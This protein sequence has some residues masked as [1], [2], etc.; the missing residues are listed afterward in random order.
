M[1]PEAV[2]AV[3][4]YLRLKSDIVA[5]RFSP[6][7]LLVE[8]KIAAEYDMSIVPLRDA[9]QRLL[10]EGLIE[11]AP[12][13]GYRLPV[14]SEAGLKDLYAWH[15]A[16][17]GLALKHQREERS[18]ETVS[19]RPP[20][21]LPIELEPWAATGLFRSLGDATGAGELARAISSANDRLHPARLVEGLVL[22]QS[23]EELGALRRSLE[24]E[25]GRQ[26]AKLIRAYHRRRIRHAGKIVA[27]LSNEDIRRFLDQVRASAKSDSDGA[28]GSPVDS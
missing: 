14:V 15:C 1:A 3:R 11:A 4:A 28:R 8:R 5:G 23:V 12:G 20:A 26:T 10:G 7:N 27:V 18:R 24:K 21:A 25:S 16:L 17:I 22:D 9:A 13:G 6:A 19:T 2:V